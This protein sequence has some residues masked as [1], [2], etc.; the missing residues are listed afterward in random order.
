MAFER[1]HSL[2]VAFVGVVTFA[3]AS[4]AT[5]FAWSTRS[6]EVEQ[7]LTQIGEIYLDGLVASLQASI[8]RDAAGDIDRRLR[9]AMNEQNG[10]AERAIMVFD[11]NSVATNRAGSRAL[12][13]DKRMTLKPGSVVIDRQ[14][15]TMFVARRFRDTEAHAAVALNIEPILKTYAATRNSTVLGNIL[16]AMLAAIAAAAALAAAKRGPP[17]QAAVPK[18]SAPRLVA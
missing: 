11:N 2:A 14:E 17:A 16:A 15:M 1:R 6:G 9:S 5:E 3:A 8:E 10:I 18:A 4:A 12:F 7:Q 13:S